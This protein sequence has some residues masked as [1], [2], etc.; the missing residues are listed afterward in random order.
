MLSKAL[1]H[2]DTDEGLDLLALCVG[3]TKWRE[4]FGIGKKRMD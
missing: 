2:H 4:A 3:E 1:L